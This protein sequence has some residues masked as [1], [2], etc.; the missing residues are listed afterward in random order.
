GRLRP[1]LLR[2]RPED[3]LPSLVLSLHRALGGDGRELR[4]LRREGL[5]A[6]QAERV[7]GDPRQRD[8]A[9]QR[10]QGGRVP[11][12]DVHRLCLRDGHRAGGDASLRPRR[13]A[14]PLR[15]RRPAAGA[16]L[17]MK[18]SCEW[19]TE[20]V[21]TLPPAEELAARLTRAGLEVEGLENPARALRGV[22]VAKIVGSEPHPNAE[23]LSVTRIDAGGPQLQVVCGARNY[24]VG[25][26]VPLATVGTT[27]PNGT[28]IEQASLRGVE[29][30]GMLCSPRELGLADDASGLLILPAGLKPGTP[31]AEALGLDDTVMEVNVTPNRGDALSHL[32]VGREASAGLHLPLRRKLRTPTESGGPGSEVIRIEIA[33]PEGCRRFTARVL[34]GVRIGPSPEWMRRRLERCGMRSISNVVDVTN[35]VMLELGQPFHA[36]DLDKIQGGF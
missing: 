28:T 18:V 14:Q 33:G 1:R 21:S 35:Y 31:I 24:K 17:A 6:L 7:A 19:L 20:F 25:D 11:G 34:E 27:L 2:R 9:P 5:P 32:G 3:P 12:G 15:Q 10:L 13:P 36:F 23:K 8:G 22:V 4:R 29:S 30:Q 16:V 26:L